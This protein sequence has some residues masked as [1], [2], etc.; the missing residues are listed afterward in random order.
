MIKKIITGIVCLNLMV[1]P[2]NTV[3]AKE[4]K[5]KKININVDMSNVLRPLKR[6]IAELKQRVRVLE[7]III[8]QRR[9]QITRI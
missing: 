4:K 2:I 5:T 7:A 6:E 8:E 9:Q 3:S 1:I